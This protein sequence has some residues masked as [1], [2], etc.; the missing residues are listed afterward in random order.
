MLKSMT[1][2]G[3]CEL[4]EDGKKISVEMKSVNH[5]Y[6]EI[7]LRMP[8]KL[9]Y[10]ESLIRNTIKQ[11][12]NRGKIDV[13]ISYE[14]EKE[15]LAG[16]RYNRE[17]AATYVGYIRQMAEDFGLSAD[18]SAAGLARMQDVIVNDDSSADEE[19]LKSLVERAVTGACEKFVETRLAEG[20]HLKQDIFGKL[21]GLLEGVAFIEKRSPEIVEEYR[22]KLNAKIREVLG[23]T[24][25]DQN[26]L[27]TELVIYADKICTDE[28]TVRLRAHIR[29]MKET[30]NVAANIGRKLDFI[31]QEMNREAN[32][33]LSKANDMQ[34]SD[35]AI[36]LKTE[37]EK[38]REQIQN[39]E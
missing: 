18:I 13:F 9:N 29:N 15:G 7:G 33:I 5:R 28:E 35:T 34:V 14:D 8:K 17:L 26:V 36:N 20:E 27:A 1:G 39:I 10:Y 30:L 6:C 24:Q 2:F 4:T 12:A 31:A 16:I 38:I 32:T 21:D 19:Q 11:Y 22:N 37:I 25:I 3:R 23:D